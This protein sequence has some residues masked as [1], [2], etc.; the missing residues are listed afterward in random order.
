MKY[1]FILLGGN[2][3]KV[4]TKTESNK[5]WQEYAQIGI[6]KN[7]WWEWKT[8]L[9]LWKAVW[10]GSPSKK[11]PLGLPYDPPILLLGKYLQELKTGA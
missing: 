6:I 8:V 11:L 5:C 2:N 3:K 4:K 1:Y 7:C 9:P 10:F